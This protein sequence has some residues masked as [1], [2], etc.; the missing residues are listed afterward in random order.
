[1]PIVNT[2]NGMEISDMIDWHVATKPNGDFVIEYEE[3]ELTEEEK[4]ILNDTYVRKITGKNESEREIREKAYDRA[5]KG[6]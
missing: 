2:L 5:M 1:M 4:E 6:I 3:M